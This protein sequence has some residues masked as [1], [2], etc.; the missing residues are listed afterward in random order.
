[1]QLTSGD[2]KGANFS[3]LRYCYVLCGSCVVYLGA[4]YDGACLLFCLLFHVDG[5]HPMSPFIVVV[6]SCPLQINQ[7]ILPP[8]YDSRPAIIL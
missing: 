3:S 2:L 1:M 5:G 4:I 6:Q 8:K 7:T